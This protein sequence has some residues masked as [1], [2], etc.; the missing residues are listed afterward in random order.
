M[1]R[2]VDTWIIFGAWV[3]LRSGPTFG[4]AFAA[5]VDPSR[6]AFVPRGVGNSFQT[7][8]TGLRLSKAFGLSDVFF[9]NMQAR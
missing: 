1:R 3:D 9:V 2:W 7:L 5:E 6:A 4:T 8:D